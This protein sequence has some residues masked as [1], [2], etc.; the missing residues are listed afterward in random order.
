MKGAETPLAILF[1]FFAKT[2][3]IWRAIFGHGFCKENGLTNPTYIAS[4]RDKP[5]RSSMHGGILSHQDPT[6]ADPLSSG[7]RPG[8]CPLM[9]S[10][11]PPYGI[12]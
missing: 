6:R 10:A 9:A 3:R 11:V 8:R 12:C 4:D 2:S 1:F 7:I 5:S